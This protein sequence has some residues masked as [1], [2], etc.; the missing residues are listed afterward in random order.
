MRQPL[1]P[2]HYVTE[3]IVTLLVA[4]CVAGDCPAQDATQQKSSN[5]SDAPKVKGIVPVLAEGVELEIIAEHPDLATPTGIDIDQNGAVW[6]TANHT[7]FRPEQYQGPPKDEVLIFKPN[8]E[9]IVFFSN[10]ENTMDLELDSSGMVYLA[11]RDKILR[12]LDRDH[13]QV[14]DG[15]DTIIQLQTDA[16]YPHNGMSGLTWSPDGNLVFSMG[17][18]FA[19]PWTL[20]GSDGRTLK[21]SGEGGIF[22]CS[23]NGESLRR[24]AKG[25]WNPF[26]LCYRN[27]EL[28]AAEN[29]PGSR[30]PCRLLH[31][32][33]GGD[34]G[35]QRKYGN[36]AYHPFV[37]WNGELQDTLPMLHPL[38][39]APCGIVP[40]ADGL[41]VTSWTEHRIDYY[42][43][44]KN[45]ASFATN[46]VTLVEGGRDFRPTCLTSD[47]RN[48]LY[49]TDWVTGSYA[50]HGKGRVWSMEIDQQLLQSN[51]HAAT[52]S[53]ESFSKPIP[54]EASIFTDKNLAQLL[55]LAK[56]TTDPFARV[57]IMKQI[58]SLATKRDV[59]DLEKIDVID[60]VNLLLALKR[61]SPKDGQ[62]ALHFLQ[63]ES[64]MVQFEALRWIAD[65]EIKDGLPQVVE[66][67]ARPDIDFRRFE[68]TL[69]A[70]NTLQGNASLGVA[71]QSML[72]KL[73]NDNE[74]SNVV[75]SH[76]LRLI[77]PKPS[78]L[79][80]ELWE[81]LKKEDDLRLLTELV[82]TL[83][84][85]AT[86][87]S[88]DFLH[89]IA[90]DE[91]IPATI[92]AD[93]IAGLES[94]SNSNHATLM[95]LAA[96]QERSIR[97][98][99]LR[100]LRFSDLDSEKR[101]RLKVISE[102]HPESR[103]LVT[104]IL[105][106]ETLTSRPSSTTIQ[107][108]ARPSP[109]NINLWSKRLASITSPVDLAA[110]RRI[111]HHRTVG[112]CGKCHRHLGRGKTLGPD[113]S[114]ASK[115]VHPNRLLT[116][117]LQPSRDVD[118]QYHA[119][120]LLM[121]DG[122]TFTGI[123]LRDGGGGSEV[124][125]NLL[126]EEEVLKTEQI[127]NRKELQSSLMPEGL[128]E[129]MT[130]REIRDLLAFISDSPL[131]DASAFSKPQGLP[132]A[133]SPTDLS[134]LVIKSNPPNVSKEVSS[135]ENVNPN[136]LIAQ[137]S[138]KDSSQSKEAES[139]L[140]TALVSLKDKNIQDWV[141]DWWLD[142]DDGYGGWLTIAAENQSYTGE[143]L[144]RVGSP[145]PVNVERIDEHHLQLTRKNKRAM[146]IFLASLSDGKLTIRLKETE[147]FA[148]GEKC[149]P[150]PAAPDFNN[151]RFGKRISIF[152][153]KDL[154]GWALQPKAAKNGWRVED[155]VLVNETPKTDFS[156]YGEYG[157][158]RTVS[159]F[160]DCKLH[161]EF[162]IDEN[163]NSGV[164]LRGLYEAQVVDR[165]SKMQGI[166]GPGSIFGRISPSMNAGREGGSWQSYE[167]TLIDRHLTVQLND[168]LVI[169]NQPIR[170]C[171]GGALFGNINNDGPVYLQ[172]DHT[173]VS[174]RN[175]WIRRRID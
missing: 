168:R 37:C 73:L 92:R 152:N 11:Q 97:E 62:M 89:S 76:L 133:T 105:A 28:F 43:L 173:S 150:M 51:N 75:K 165:N 127:V 2:S 146:S 95:D 130:D 8:G 115:N 18:N 174:Y 153:G 160:G 39:E 161:L 128:Y 94:S 50:L 154:S 7:H 171:T 87:E 79:P 72:T 121:D 149:P 126:G 129:Q 158:L 17:E 155:G 166:N 81:T 44:K 64:E 151:V 71:D 93:A 159:E 61:S 56:R 1:Q 162:K 107:E 80:T 116:A 122:R 110:G 148:S 9:R 57:P 90:V 172:G 10:T 157:N 96:H 15:T 31:I 86:Q 47:D 66:F 55:M 34:Y 104:A 103:D 138:L 74:T 169:D 120:M 65:E 119:R 68:A 24:I 142:F 125:R 135:G 12:L 84:L 147:Q 52:T 46:R 164:Y 22:T 32:I 108:Q 144:W 27:G 4:T 111:F 60:Q 40:F 136:G 163:C 19:E 69:A 21:G 49:F 78:H 124:Y 20:T 6:I 101:E 48:K 3:L 54:E 99:S 83:T 5:T 175:L 59:Q 118:P 85:L 112:T 113:L 30:P 170:G 140:S 13:D 25:F 102:Q 114:A 58:A 53:K 70:I 45:G 26:A 123:L 42:P 132:I 36:A 29:D 38:G 77:Q 141:G 167:I 145:R 106:P 88:S 63:S 14:C 156:A 16:T 139:Y 143:L 109:Q 23:P 41:V 137:T 35:Y 33:E 117:L 131:Q 91:S 82:R 100:S 134:Q 98:E 67:L